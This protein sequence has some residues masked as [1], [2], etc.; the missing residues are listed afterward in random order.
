MRTEKT[1]SLILSLLLII[2]LLGGCAETGSVVKVVSVTP[3]ELIAPT[4]GERNPA[5]EAVADGANDFAFRLGT[6]LAEQYENENLVVSPF[7]VW[8][9]L[10]ALVNATDETAK[11]ALLEALGAQGISEENLDTAVSRMLYDLT[12]ERERVWAEEGGYEYHN[13]LQIANAI[14]V[15][16]EVTLDKNFAQT[17]A[18]YYRGNAINVDFS[19]PEAVDAVNKWASENTEGLITEIVKELDPETLCAIA[20]AIYFSDRWD[21]EF[22][23]DS[24]REDVFHS[25]SGDSTAQFMYRQGDMLPYYEDEQVQAMPM[26]FKTGGGMLIILPRDGNA[27]GLLSSMTNER[28]NGIFKDM[29]SRTGE[30]LLPRFSIEGDAMPLNDTLSAMGIPLFDGETPLI[31]GLI[32]QDIPL[33]LSQAVHKALI[34]VDEKGTTAAAV[35]VMV[36]AGAAMPEPTEPFVMNCNKPFVFVLYGDTYDGG[37]QVLFTGMVNNV[38]DS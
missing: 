8:L 17:F 36:A 16:N 27:T 3:Q 37:A 11:P 12:Q 25:P 4:F 19:S 2:S 21:W 1:I 31:T 38:V 15:D 22:N 26:R 5:A 18:D 10:A 20:N 14:F 13:P 30:L 28:F 24:T 29:I 6:A 34:K 35:T 7:S 33:F 23:S 9:P 32:E